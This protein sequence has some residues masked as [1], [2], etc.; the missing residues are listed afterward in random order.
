LIKSSEIMG[1]VTVTI[2]LEL[3]REILKLPS[4]CKLTRVR[5][6]WEQEGTSEMQVLVESLELEEVSPGH[7]IPEAKILIHFDAEGIETSE[8]IT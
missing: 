7:V 3:L 8:L 2:S 5:Q 4:H 6:T 1:K